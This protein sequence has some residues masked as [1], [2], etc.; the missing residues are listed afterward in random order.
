MLNIYETGTERRSK[1]ASLLGSV[2][3]HV[4]LVLALYQV[5][6]VVPRLNHYAITQLYLP[7]A[8]PPP[9]QAP[10]LP[11]PLVAPPVATHLVAPPPSALLARLPLHQ[12]RADLAA[13]PELTV[14]RSA[15]PPVR[16]PVLS[17][18]TPVAPAPPPP[19]FASAR[20]AALAT[21]PT[22]SLRTGDFGAIPTAVAPVVAARLELPT[23]AFGSVPADTPHSSPRNTAVG[24]SGFG[25]PG[26]VAT[27][28]HRGPAVTASNSFGG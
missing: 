2:A 10:A 16:Q 12:P 27:N 1:S 22:V 20:P 9:R 3:V 24:P 26:V 13:P 6:T 5:R 19:V 28:P 11:P 18:P 23:G 7:A 17:S 25:S 21:P 4:A 14:I 8:G 15:L